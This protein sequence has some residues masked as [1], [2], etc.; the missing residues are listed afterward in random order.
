M[1][2]LSLNL[3]QPQHTPAGLLIGSMHYAGL[4]DEALTG[5]EARGCPSTGGRN[6][7]YLEMPEKDINAFVALVAETYPHRKDEVEAFKA[8]VQEKIDE[9]KE[10]AF[11]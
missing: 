6:T 3:S 2:K 7:L 5:K 4:L 10:K 8:L 1:R 11:A 9:A